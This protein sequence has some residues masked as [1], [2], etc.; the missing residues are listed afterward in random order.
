MW[1]KEKIFER[2]SVCEE[3]DKSHIYKCEKVKG[4]TPIYRPKIG[5]KKEIIHVQSLLVQLTYP[6]SSA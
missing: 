4:E 5:S 3:G 2:E 1:E 6:L